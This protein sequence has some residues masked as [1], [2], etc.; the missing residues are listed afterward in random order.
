LRIISRKAVAEKSADW[1]LIELKNSHQR[2]I[3]GLEKLDELLAQPAP[4]LQSYL[5]L[6]RELL[7]ASRARSSAVQTAHDPI[8]EH[9]DQAAEVELSR[10]LRARQ[11][12]MGLS[13]DHLSTWSGWVIAANWSRHRLAQRALRSHWLDLIELEQSVLYPML[14]QRATD[15]RGA[16]LPPRCQ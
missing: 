3:S 4:D 7:S 12:M 14:Q 1:L 10:T 11:K 13:A 16:S 2:V 9:A 6:R 5:A 8:I 15:L